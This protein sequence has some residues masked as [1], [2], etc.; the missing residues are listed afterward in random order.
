MS[1]P[2]EKNFP[3]PVSTVARTCSCS[4]F[5]RKQVESSS[6]IWSSSALTGPRSSLTSAIPSLID[7]AAQARQRFA[8]FLRAAIQLLHP[9]LAEA[10]GR[11][12]VDPPA[13]ERRRSGD[14]GPV[15]VED[16]PN[17]GGDLV[18]AL[19]GADRT[20]PVLDGVP[21]QRFAV[22]R[23]QAPP[24]L[25][26]GEHVARADQRLREQVEDAGTALDEDLVSGD[27]GDALLD[28]FRVEDLAEDLR[29]ARQHGAGDL[30]VLV[31]RL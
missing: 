7:V 9:L 6:T 14:V 4:A 27:R 31:P 1:K 18:G 13:L 8:R 11:R 29:G 12:V 21:I 5:C 19:A 23:A 17:G 22:R 20:E 30:V 24:D 15:Q 26:S 28:G 25:A 10:E 2:K 16:A 3:V